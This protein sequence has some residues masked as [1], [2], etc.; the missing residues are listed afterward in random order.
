MNPAAAPYSYDMLV[1]DYALGC[2]IWFL[3]LV[4]LGTGAFPGFDKPEAARS[5][6]LWGRGMGRIR[7]ALTELGCPALVDRIAAA[8]A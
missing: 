2:V 7:Y 8:I 5:K 1:E 4:S 3:A 6:R